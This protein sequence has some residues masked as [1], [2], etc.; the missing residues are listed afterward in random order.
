MLQKTFSHNTQTDTHRKKANKKKEIQ[1]KLTQTAVKTSNSNNNIT[2]TNGNNT[3]N[4][5]PT[6]SR[7]NGVKQKMKLIIFCTY[8]ED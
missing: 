5:K 2:Q 8:I 1:A 7:L 3:E 4:T 6:E